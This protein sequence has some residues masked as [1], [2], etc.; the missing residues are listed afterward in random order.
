MTLAQTALKRSWPLQP[1][2][3]SVE[4]SILT[5]EWYSRKANLFSTYRIDGSDVKLSCL[6]PPQ[7]LQSLSEKLGYCS[8]LIS[9][10]CTH[11]I[12][13]LGLVLGRS[14]DCKPRCG[15]EGT[16]DLG[17]GTHGKMSMSDVGE[18]RL[19]GMSWMTSDVA[20][21]LYNV[22]TTTLVKAN[23]PANVRGK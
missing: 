17:E 13:V 11:P 10:E 16:L 1:L 6:V 20:L 19:V 9:N 8:D 22:G 5:L 15:E 21:S 23:L 18:V 4:I 2:V 3:L 12:P 14:D 7:H